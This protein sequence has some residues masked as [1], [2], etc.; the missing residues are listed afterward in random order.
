VRSEGLEE[1]HRVVIDGSHPEDEPVGPREE[2]SSLPYED[3]GVWA[4]PRRTKV[5]AGDTVWKR[6]L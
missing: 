4:P 6:R 2:W 3:E 1:K 5:C